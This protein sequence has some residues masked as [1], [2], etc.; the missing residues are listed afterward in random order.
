M[1]LAIINDTYADV[2][3]EIAAA[4]TEMQLTHYI[5]N[6]FGK[7]FAKKQTPEE[8]DEESKIEDAMIKKIRQTLLQY[9]FRYIFVCCLTKI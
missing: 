4:P 1:F 8:E 7:F 2:K 3:A 5:R 6:L 9:N